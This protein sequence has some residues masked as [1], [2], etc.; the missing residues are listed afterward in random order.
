[1]FLYYILN[2]KHESML[3]RFLEAQIEN[4]TAKDWVTTVKKDLDEL[5]LNVTFAEIAAMRKGSFKT[6]LRK[7]IEEKALEYLNGKKSSHSK[8]MKLKH[9]VLQMQTYLMP[10]KAKISREEKQLIFSMRSEVTEVKM[11]FKRMHENYECE[12]CDEEVETQEHIIECK[13]LL[14]M[15]ENSNEI[16]IPKYEK[17]LDGTPRDKIEIARLFKANMN[18]RKLFMDNRKKNG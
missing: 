4:P 10:N 2:E 1:M 8:V 14:N 5:N 16:S 6:M 17:L 9:E 15:N 3:Y 12:V 11:N 13:S 7:S 18:K